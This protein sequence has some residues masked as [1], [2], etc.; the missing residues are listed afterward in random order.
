MDEKDIK[1]VVGGLLVQDRDLDLIANEIKCVTKRKPTNDEMQA[2][3]FAWKVCK[4]V[5]SNAI[6]YS[7]KDMIIG[8]GAGQMSRVDSAKIGII[9]SN[10]DINGSVLASDAFFPFRDGVDAAAKAGVVAIIQPG[11]SV[12]DVEVI[13]ACNE[14]DIAMVFTGMRHF[15]H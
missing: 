8:V 1:K 4:H 14:Y 5:K 10:F 15:R 13:D 12:R 2:L 6:V 9:K 11:G 7:Y 3:D